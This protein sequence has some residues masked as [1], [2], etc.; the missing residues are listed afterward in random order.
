[1]QAPWNLDDSHEG[2]QAEP[3]DLNAWTK[4]GTQ[5]L[6]TGPHQEERSTA[7]APHLS[8]PAHSPFASRCIFS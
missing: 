5:A 2:H 8:R 4:Q 7:C 6:I 3:E 1:M